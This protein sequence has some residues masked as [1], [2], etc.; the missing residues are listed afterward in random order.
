MPAAPSRV[1]SGHTGLK[2][3]AV[4]FAN[5]ARLGVRLEGT[6]QAELC[7]ALEGRPRQPNRN[8]RLQ[9]GALWEGPAAAK[10]AQDE[11]SRLR[12]CA[13]AS[14]PVL[15]G[16]AAA[17]D[18]EGMS[19]RDA[20]AAEWQRRGSHLASPPLRPL[21]LKLVAT[22][23]PGGPWPANAWQLGLGV[24]V[25]ELAGAGRPARD[26]GPAQQAEESGSHG[27]REDL[28]PAAAR[29]SPPR[30][31]VRLLV[32]RLVRHGGLHDEEVGSALGVHLR[33]IRE[34]GLELVGV[35]A[36]GDGRG[37]LRLAPELLALDCELPLHPLADLPVAAA[38][39]RRAAVADG[40][41]R[42]RLR[43]PGVRHE[44]RGLLAVAQE[45]HG[46]DRHVVAAEVHDVQV[47]ERVQVPERAQAAA[48]LRLVLH[49]HAKPLESL[50][51]DAEGLVLGHHG[52]LVDLRDHLVIIPEAP[53]VGRR[54]GR[55]KVPQA[56]VR[57]DVPAAEDPEVV[58]A[59]VGLQQGKALGCRGVPPVV[60]HGRAPR[61]Q[62]RTDGV[63]DEA[64]LAP[65]ELPHGHHDVVRAH[66]RHGVRVPRVDVVHGAPRSYVEALPAEAVALTVE[67]DLLLGVP[68]AVLVRELVP[69]EK[70]HVPPVF[71]PALHEERVGRPA[72]HVRGAPCGG[73]FANLSPPLVAASP[74]VEVYDCLLGRI[75]ELRRRT[76]RGLLRGVPVAEPVDARV[77]LAG[78]AARV[79]AQVLRRA[80][81]LRLAVVA[82]RV[83][84]EAEAQQRAMREQRRRGPGAAAGPQRT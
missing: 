2:C 17:V 80:V 78:P 33:L 7:P 40:G 68:G 55:G 6:R 58:L 28:Q 32:N 12:P 54:G 69:V 51:W 82:P 18:L 10:R 16:A 52:G 26:E 66:V 3:T 37:A 30:R 62:L 74:A 36:A 9:V 53:H 43:D 41:A 50:V 72:A 42:L 22:L 64:D 63:A 84:V 81:R 45:V 46:E 70:P 47:S 48:P 65:G 21:R 14:T 38:G 25:G 61:G 29:V 57:G 59:E 49:Q 83:D 23:G 8:D 5:S 39:R 79:A 34:A 67:P 71:E 24:V 77:Q 44:P 13:A 15:G 73:P 35:V 75:V 60:Q 20:G 11:A 76:A 19:A 56:R 4:D 31:L 27:H 1:C